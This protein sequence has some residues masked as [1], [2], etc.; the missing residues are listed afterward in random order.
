MDKIVTPVCADKF[1][2]LV[3]KTGYS[4]KERQFLI[5]GFRQGFSLKYKGPFDRR[6]T[7]PNIPFTPG[8]GSEI[9]L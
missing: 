1:E 8:V 5:K 4:V 3:I 2:E 7:A 9:E 6:D